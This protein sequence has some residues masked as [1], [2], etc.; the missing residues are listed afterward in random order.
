VLVA[1][2]VDPDAEDETAVKRANREAMRGAIAD[3]LE[4][5]TADAVHALVERRDDAGNIYYGGD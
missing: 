3:A 2:W 5:P 4:P 1:V